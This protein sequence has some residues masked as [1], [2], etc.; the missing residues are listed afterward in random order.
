MQNQYRKLLQIPASRLD[1][2]NAIFSNPKMQVINDFLEVIEK[3]GTPEEI[4]QKA[5][6]GRSLNALLERVES[7]KPEYMEDLRW[8]EQ[9]RDKGVFISVA[10]YRRKVLGD[11]ADTIQFNDEYAVTLDRK[12]VV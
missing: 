3:Y 5:Q 9:Q 2:I 1:D 10:D 8:L 6:N 4:N 11:K 7:I 12:S